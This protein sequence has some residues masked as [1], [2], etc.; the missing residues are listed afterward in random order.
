MLHSLASGWEAVVLM[1]PH[2]S[3]K[4]TNSA[5]RAYFKNKAILTIIFQICSTEKHETLSL[6]MA[7][8]GTL[9]Y[10]LQGFVN[11]MQT[12]HVVCCPNA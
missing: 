12:I 7:S 1:A 11:F 3:I 9:K 5:V 4:I 8:S 2:S 6:D 10:I